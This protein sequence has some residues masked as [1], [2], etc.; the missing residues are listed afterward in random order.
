ME[1][2]YIVSKF[3]VHLQWLFLPFQIFPEN[4]SD[5]IEHR[6]SEMEKVLSDYNN[7]SE[8]PRV[9]SRGGPTARLHGE[10]HQYILKVARR[11]TNIVRN[12]AVRTGHGSH[13]RSPGARGAAEAPS[14]ATRLRPVERRTSQPHRRPNRRPR[15]R[16]ART[17]RGATARAARMEQSKTISP[18]GRLEYTAWRN[19]CTRTT[20]HH[21]R[22]AT[23]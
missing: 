9:A 19:S 14:E 16:S 18:P 1:I 21:R 17:H 8:P 11:F 5:G 10:Y 3:P 4:Y 22:Y 6:R 20:T 12:E 23:R 7:A 2:H 15:R 13:V